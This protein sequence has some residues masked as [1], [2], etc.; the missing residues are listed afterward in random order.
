MLARVA[1]NLFWMGRYIERSEHLARF[2]NVNYF[3][4]LDAPDELSQS[5]QFVLRSVMYMSANEIIDADI[6]LQ[7]EG[8]LFNVG[9]N[10]DQPYSIINTFINAHDNA[11]SS[12]DLISTELFECINR[13]NHNIKAYPIDKY[14]KSGLYDFT[15]I[16]TQ[17]SSEIRSK[18]KSTLLHDEVYAIIM[19]GV[20]I[21]R[22]IQVTRVINSK[23]S[24]VSAAKVIY[25]NES[26]ASYH[27]S[28][29]LKCVSTYDMMRRF[30]KKTPSRKTT[31]EFIILNKDC[32]RSIKN[33]LSQIYKYICIISK[34]KQITTSSAAFL[35]GKMKAEFEYKLIEDIDDNLE[36]FISDL[37]EKLGL[38]AEKLEDNYFKITDPV[39]VKEQVQKQESI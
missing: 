34:N 38:I 31:L 13:I 16:V 33:C 36:E 22:A 20:Y 8:V 25:G 29:L 32:P 19:L 11:R 4:S 5:R 27:W 1:N 7:E 6:T 28:T 23:L 9:L 37:I 35:I 17:S 15:T 2:L 10:L 30:Y 12:R 26:E 18:I 21:E 24:D 39:F 3:S 14:V